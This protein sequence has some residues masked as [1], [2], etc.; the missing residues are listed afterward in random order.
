MA[1]NAIDTSIYTHKRAQDRTDCVQFVTK[2][3]FTKKKKKK[4]VI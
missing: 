2:I 1:S 3:F 4:L